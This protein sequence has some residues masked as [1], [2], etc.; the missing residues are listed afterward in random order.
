MPVSKRLPT[1][2]TVKPYWQSACGRVTVHVG[3]CREVMAKLEPETFHA[4][5]TDPPYGLEFDVGQVKGN[6]D[7]P[8]KHTQASQRRVDEFDNPVKRKYLWHNVEYVRD[9]PAFQQWFLGCAQAILRVAKPG[10]HLLSFGGTRMWHRMTCAVEDA[11][12]EIRDCIV[13][14]YSSGYPKGRDISKDIDRILGA[15]RQVVGTIEMSDTTKVRPGF[16]GASHNNGVMA[17]RQVELT[18]PATDEARQW[19]GW[20]TTLKPAW[21][22]VLVSRKLAGGPIT[23]NILDNGCGGININDCR[24]D[25]RWPA[26]LIHDGSPDVV[27]TMPD[28]TSRVFYS[29]KSNDSDR[30]HGSTATAHPTVKPLDLMRYLVRLV[31]APGGTVLDPFMGSGSTGCAAVMEGT[32]FVGIEQSVEYADIAVGRIKLALMSAPGAVELKVRG[33]GAPKPQPVKAAV[34]MV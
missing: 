16:T 29:A 12:F 17:K 22:P 30:P 7:A 27:S 2:Q 20:N 34:G 32:K 25:G 23:Q 28:G 19:D 3:D 11:G 21:E 4:V 26:N 24:A 15:T 5:V 10:A 31:C 14:C 9:G 6:W 1:A 8:W 18:E 13:W 33:G